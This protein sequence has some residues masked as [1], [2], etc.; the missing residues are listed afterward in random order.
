MGL[1]SQILGGLAGSSLGGRPESRR[2]GGLSP[3][4][5]SL[6][7]VVLSMLNQRRRTSAGT[8]GAGSLG[9]LGDLIGRFGQRGYGQQAASWVGT[10]ANEPLPEEAID[11]VF[12]TDELH[13]IAQQAGVSNEDARSG[14][15]QLLPDVVDHFT[16]EGAIPEGE[17]LANSVDDYLK[18]VS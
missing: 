12:T 6:L 2:T 7:P 18:R 3:I 8:D 16:P 13:H 5:M 15:S 1:L 10:G 14:L 17:A 11:N 4:L 9:G